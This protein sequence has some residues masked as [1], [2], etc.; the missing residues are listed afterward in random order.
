MSEFLDK[1]LAE[2]L[3]SD[4]SEVVDIRHDLHA[5]PQGAFEEVHASGVI[6]KE[7]ERAGVQFMAPK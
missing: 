1:A 7:L 5:H 4:L 6:Q 3:L 2:F